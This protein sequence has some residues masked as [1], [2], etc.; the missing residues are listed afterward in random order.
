MSL[1]VLSCALFLSS[2]S[3]SFPLPLFFLP[4]AISVRVPLLV[5]RVPVM[6]AVF[7]PSVLLLRSLLPPLVCCGGWGAVIFRAGGVLL[8]KTAMVH[9]F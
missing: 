9:G 3:F 1:S 4:P 7:P 5:F 6:P 2:A 8:V